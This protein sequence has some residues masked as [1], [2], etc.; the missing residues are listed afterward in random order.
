MIE[1]TERSGGLE[2]GLRKSRGGFMSRL[3][4]LLAGDAISPETW[5]DVEET[6]IAGDVG[7]TLA[8]EVVERAQRGS[9]RRWG[10]R[11]GSP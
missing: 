6:L 9:L 3:R 1:D 8:T 2:D 10:D 11:R 5:S 7:A 4:G